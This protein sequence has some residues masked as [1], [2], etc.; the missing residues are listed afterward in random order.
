MTV[1]Q[2]SKTL[3]IPMLAI[4]QII[5]DG[6]LHPVSFDVF[7]EK[8]VEKLKCEEHHYLSSLL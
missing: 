8:E 4:G 7:D 5:F 3:D 6:K 2:V 1:E